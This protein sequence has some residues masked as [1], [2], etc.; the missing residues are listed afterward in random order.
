MSSHFYLTTGQVEVELKSSSESSSE[1]PSEAC[2]VHPPLSPSP[3]PLS[4][5]IVYPQTSLIKTYANRKSRVE[6]ATY[7][8]IV[9]AECNLNH[10]LKRFI[11]YLFGIEN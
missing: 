1:R 5:S 10:N 2:R 4:L 9:A 3:S 6:S 11:R 7:Q 8:I